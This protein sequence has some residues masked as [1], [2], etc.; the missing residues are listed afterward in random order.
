MKRLKTSRKIELCLLDHI[1]ELRNGY[2]IVAY[3]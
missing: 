2:E 3:Y 1:S